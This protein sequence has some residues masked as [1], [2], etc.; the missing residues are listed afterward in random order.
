[1]TACNTDV[2]SVVLVQL[3][4]KKRSY[5]KTALSTAKNI[6]LSYMSL[7]TLLPLPTP[8]G[9]NKFFPFFFF[10]FFLFFFLFFSKSCTLVFS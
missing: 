1:M 4:I 5:S 8:F 2:T 6:S 7:D 3:D 10:L 9:S